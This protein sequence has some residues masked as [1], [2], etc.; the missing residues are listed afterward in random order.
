M[1]S[2]NLIIT[3]GLSAVLL[4]SCQDS[5]GPEPP[6]PGKRDY[7]W[8]I[9]TISYTGSLQ[10]LLT[11]IWASSPTDV[12][13]VGHNDQNRGQMYHYNG[14]TWTPALLAVSDGGSIAGGF[15]LSAIYGFTPNDIY[16]VG[17]R[18]QSN[19][20]PPPNFLDSSLIIHFDGIRWTEAELERGRG[21]SGIWGK[22]S[23]DLF[24]VGWLG[25][26]FR[27]D[28]LG[29]KRFQTNDSFGYNR[30]VGNETE[31]YLLGS[32]SLN[33]TPDHVSRDYLL[34]WKDT[35]FVV[36]DSIIEVP[37][38]SPTFGHLAIEGIQ[39]TIYTA[40]WGAFAKKGL[41]WKRISALGMETFYDIFGTRNEHIFICG[42]G[43]T[44]FH[45]NGSDWKK[46]DIPGD[47][48]L[49]LYGVWCDE[50][51]VFVLGSDGYRSFVI[52]GK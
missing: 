15:D 18:I 6:K 48:L 41:G 29:W 31:V 19:P 9:D 23:D 39:G 26:L 4:T 34:E 20:T 27:Y 24:A 22:R 21:L 35:S 14:L 1:K 12:Y 45:F 52:H 30:L 51:E 25:T 44:L 36:I 3:I 37:G 7:V 8:S 13:V 47:S 42:F 49:P 10:T 2:N 16:A 17:E 5:T 50:E 38:A 11:T 32:I 40:G 28:G 33:Y 46:L 43:K